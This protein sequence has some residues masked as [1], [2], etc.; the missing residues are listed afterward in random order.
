MLKDNFFYLFDYT[1]TNHSEINFTIRLNLE[2]IIYQAHFL[3]NPITPGVCI[4]QIIKELFSYLKQT[5]FTIKKIKSA[6]FLHPIVP[7]V[8]NIVNFK[9]NWEENNGL[10][11]LKTAVYY[12]DVVFSKINLESVPKTHFFP[13]QSSDASL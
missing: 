3:N 12:Q 2:H 1:D 8:H 13:L 7:T 5:D 11:C 4:I 10:F 9:I 6:K